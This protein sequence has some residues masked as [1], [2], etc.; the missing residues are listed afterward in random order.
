[1]HKK[2][3]IINLNKRKTKVLSDN[4]PG[5]EKILILIESVDVVT[6]NL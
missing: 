1:M 4:H 5:G 3:I 6:K 2:S